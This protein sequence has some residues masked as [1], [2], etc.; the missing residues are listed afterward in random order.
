MHDTLNSPPFSLSVRHNRH[1]IALHNKITSPLTLADHPLS[2]VL[3]EDN[4]Q[5]MLIVKNVK[6]LRKY[7]ILILIFKSI[8]KVNYS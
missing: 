7:I 6:L 5:N 4:Y 3:A 8:Q 2:K 1:S